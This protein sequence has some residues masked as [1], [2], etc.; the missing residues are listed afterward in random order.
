MVILPPSFEAA[1]SHLG[2]SAPPS[3]FRLCPSRQQPLPSRAVP[4]SLACSS[5]SCPITTPSAEEAGKPCDKPAMRAPSSGGRDVNIGMAFSALWVFSGEVLGTRGPPLTPP[6]CVVHPESSGSRGE[7][8]DSGPRC[9][10]VS[11]CQVPPDW[12]F[13]SVTHST[14]ASQAGGLHGCWVAL[15]PVSALHGLGWCCLIPLPPDDCLRSQLP[16]HW[17][18]CFWGKVLGEEFRN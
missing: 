6:S 14:E 16:H 2:V 12:S 1:R 13:C 18:L 4:Q 5:C 7:R 10:P 3:P 9:L 17:A 8:R 11:R 15:T